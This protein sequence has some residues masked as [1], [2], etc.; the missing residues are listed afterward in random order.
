MEQ[1]VIKYGSPLHAD[2]AAAIRR[3]YEFSNRKMVDEAERW[4][5]SEKEH[6]FYITDEDFEDM[7][8]KEDKKSDTF[9]TLV[10]P[11]SYAMVLSAHTYW[12]TVFLAR[13]PILQFSARHGETEMQTMAV[14]ALMDYQTQVGEHLVPYYVWLLDVAKYGIGVVSNYWDEE[15]ITVSQ[16]ISKPKTYLGVPIPGTNQKVKQRKQIPGYM[17]EKVFNVRP[18]DFVRDPRVSAQ[19]LQRGEFCGRRFEVGWTEILKGREQGKYF[20]VEALSQTVRGSTDHLND[21]SASEIDKPM[22][23][24]G[25]PDFIDKNDMGFVTL[26]E[27][28]IDIVPKDWGL[29][30]SSYSEK[31]VFTMANPDGGA[32]IIGAQPFGMD[33]DKFPYSVIEYEMDGYAYGKR[34]MY[35]VLRSL[36]Q[37]MD[38]LLNTHFYNIRR[39]IN[40]MFFVDPSRVVMKDILDPRPGKLVRMKPAFYGTPI[41]EA[42]HQIQVGDSTQGHVNDSEIMGSLMQRVT[43][44]NDN[45]M[46]ML[47]QGG[48]KTATEI[49]TSSQ[50][51]INRLK[52]NAEYFSAMGFSPLAQRMLQETQQLYDLEREFKI[53]GRII[54]NDQDFLKVT[55][56]AIAGFYDFIPVDGT[57][58]IDRMA[59]LNVWTQLLAQI[60]Q[61]PQVANN[62]DLG[63]VFAWMAQLGGIRNLQ[64]F[65]IKVQPDQQVTQGA[66]AGNLVPQGTPAPGGGGP[67]PSLQLLEHLGQLGG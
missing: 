50:M 48:R 33:H 14:Q 60:R 63:K 24:D 11:Y 23:L 17:G 45:I 37:T 1:F 51:G 46:A 52:T 67:V 32:V 64:E 34:G 41:E 43:G 10:I 16:I 4:R 29:G 6:L 21:L 27:M 59:Q 47:S 13:N 7:A 39:G 40:N 35:D 22:S 12:T 54:G 42:F 5:K 20:N 25:S 66:Q 61:I 26:L 18:W 65:R 8:A 49:R 9:K 3:R 15:K 19:N 36:Q 56:D 57:M 53:V 58:P 28:F 62:Y 44:I 38:W 30:T 55:P 31:W 2:T